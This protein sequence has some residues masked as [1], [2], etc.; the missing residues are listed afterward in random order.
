MPRKP[1]R[2]VSKRRKKTPSGPPRAPPGRTSDRALDEALHYLR[3]GNLGRAQVL[4]SDILRREPDHVQ[5]LLSLGNI[6]AQTTGLEPALAIFQ[7]AA[8][9]EPSNPAPFA[10][11]GRALAAMGRLEEAT[12]ALEDAVRRDNNSPE[13]HFLLGN[14]HSQKGQYDSAITAYGTALRLRPAFA[15]AS[16][17]LGAVLKERGRLGDA[18]GA[19]QKAISAEPSL[20]IAHTNLGAALTELGQLDEAISA[21]EQATKLAPGD[22]RGYI[23]LGVCLKEKGR[24]DDA[25]AAYQHAIEIDPDSINAHINMGNALRSLNRLDEAAKCYG[26]V[27]ALDPNNA[28]AHSS[29]AS[30]HLQ[31][32]RP[33]EALEICNAYLGKHPYNSLLHAGKSVALRELEDFDTLEA[34]VDPDRV[35]Y[36]QKLPVPDGYVSLEA[37]NSQLSRHVVEHPSLVESPTSHA[38]RHGY[39]TGELLTEPLGPMESFEILVRAAIDEYLQSVRSHAYLN[40]SPSKTRLN[41]WGVV[42][43]DQGHQVSHIHPTAWISG[44]YYPKLPMLGGEPNRAGWIEFGRPG[45]EFPFSFE[46]RVRS[47]RPEE[48][49]LLLFPSYLYHRTVPLDT[50]LPR[51]S[52]A[53]DLTRESEEFL[54]PYDRIKRPTQNK[55]VDVLRP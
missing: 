39:H 5:A 38:T 40:P 55:A 31:A 11:M 52:I 10:Q 44:V 7:H 46:P 13:L 8:D 23:N 6:T 3:A 18:V 37:F 45:R 34:L 12:A 29:R 24:Y 16:C 43:N 30:L 14:I 49:L 51:I 1:G 48:G 50:H 20:A 15:Q 32:G 22:V 25:A 21:C 54:P 47:F 33:R 27:T 17:N 28:Q 4:L 9:C 53:F 35:I 42:M 2:L 26:R 36:T 41:I 19:Y